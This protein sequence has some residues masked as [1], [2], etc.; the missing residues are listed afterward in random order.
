MAWLTAVW[1]YPAVQWAPCEHVPEGHWDPSF[2]PP[3]QDVP[4]P[5]KGHKS[6]TIHHL[7]SSLTFIAKESIIHP[8][9]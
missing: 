5:G 7:L 6:H 2:S 4:I 1:E 3:A 8:L 9:Q